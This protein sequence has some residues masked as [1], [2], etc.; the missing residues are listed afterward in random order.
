VEAFKS[1]PSVAATPQHQRDLEFCTSLLERTPNDNN[2][3]LVKSVLS[4]VVVYATK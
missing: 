3:L 4:E 1:A 2:L